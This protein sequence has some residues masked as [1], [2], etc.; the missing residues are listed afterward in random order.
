MNEPEIKDLDQLVDEAKKAYEK[1]E[2]K[3]AAII[4][5]RAAESCRAKDDLLLAAEMANNQSVALLQAN[6][7]EAAL[8]AVHGTEEVFRQ[9]GESVKQ[10]LAI[11]NRAAALESLGQLEEAE[12][13]Y[14]RSA[15]LLKENGEMDLYAHVMKTLSAVQV[16]QGKQLEALASMRVGIEGLEKPSLKQ[17]LLKKLLKIPY[18]FIG[19]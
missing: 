8:E 15:D 2:Y 14:Q 6:D 12:A 1:G 13:A 17:R 10:A 9:A 16:R 4:F 18:K 7:A 11:G 19:Q 5:E 3:Q